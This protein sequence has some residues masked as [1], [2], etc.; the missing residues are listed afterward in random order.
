MSYFHQAIE[1]IEAGNGVPVN[2]LSLDTDGDGIFDFYNLTS[3]GIQGFEDHAFKYVVANHGTLEEYGPGPKIRGF[4]ANLAEYGY[5]QGT[6]TALAHYVNWL[7]FGGDDNWPTL[8]E[9]LRVELGVEQSEWNE[10]Y[11]R[12]TSYIPTEYRKYDWDKVSNKPASY[13]EYSVP[14]WLYDSDINFVKRKISNMTFTGNADIVEAFKEIFNFTVSFSNNRDQALRVIG[15]G[16]GVIPIP[17]A[18]GDGVADS[19]D[20]FPNDPTRSS[21]NASSAYDNDGDGEPDWWDAVAPGVALFED[22]PYKNVMFNHGTFENKT[23]IDENIGGFEAALVEHGYS[24]GTDTALAKWVDYV[25]FN[26]APDGYASFSERKNWIKNELWINELGG[27]AED[28]DNLRY[29]NLAGSTTINHFLSGFIST[30]YKQLNY[31]LDGNGERP[32]ISNFANN[33]DLRYNVNPNL[34]NYRSGYQ[35]YRYDLPNIS[36]LLDTLTFTGNPD[37]VEAF[38]EI[39]KFGAEFYDLIVSAQT[40][41]R[42][43]IKE[44]N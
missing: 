16:N 9:N 25:R 15:A 5:G 6:D 3:P 18:D 13:W 41:L 37:T 44:N 10:I 31:Q 7:R 24:Q 35:L 38:K 1:V 30:L 22:K 32:A 33:P 20:V 12:L 21:L 29:D 40:E 26:A 39:F 8:V 42:K 14:H 36:A 2:P 17:D 34:T 28:W 19:E 27:S 23:V 11:Q 43:N 4:E